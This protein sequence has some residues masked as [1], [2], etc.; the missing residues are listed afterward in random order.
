MILGGNEWD[1]VATNGTGHIDGHHPR[2]SL[3]LFPR[4]SDREMKWRPQ[5]YKLMQTP[6]EPK[7]NRYAKAAE[8][9]SEWHSGR[10]FF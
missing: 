10:G 5:Q 1:R 3:M 2:P 6:R 9:L 4:V 7:R 8:E